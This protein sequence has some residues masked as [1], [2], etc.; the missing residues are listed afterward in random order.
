MI[1]GSQITALLKMAGERSEWA[2]R[3]MTPNATKPG[4]ALTGT[5]SNPPPPKEKDKADYGFTPKTFVVFDR[6]LIY[7]NAQTSILSLF[8]RSPDSDFIT[9]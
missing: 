1:Q 4:A 3:A 9:R 8:F 2:G 7:L 5:L 6:L